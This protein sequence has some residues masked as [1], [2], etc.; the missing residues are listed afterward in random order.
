MRV[1]LVSTSYQLLISARLREPFKLECGFVKKKSLEIDLNAKP[2]RQSTQNGE[3]H[4][5]QRLF[6]VADGR[7][8]LGKVMKKNV[9]SSKT[10]TL[11]YRPSKKQSLVELQ[12]GSKWP[13]LRILNPKSFTLHQMIADPMPQFFIPFIWT[14]SRFPARKIDFLDL[15]S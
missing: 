1:P 10:T 3:L 15:E 6:V 5:P 8:Q 4:T 13:L 2:L 7:N 9:K 12:P 11:Y 14:G